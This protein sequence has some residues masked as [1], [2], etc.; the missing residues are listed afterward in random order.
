MSKSH[1]YT[2]STSLRKFTKTPGLSCLNPMDL[3]VIFA[4]ARDCGKYYQYPRKQDGGPQ[5][6]SWGNGVAQFRTLEYTS[7]KD[8]PIGL[9][10]R[11]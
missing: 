5:F 8:Y 4:E 9:S 2:F 6:Q 11:Q 3:G 7:H 10:G 1:L